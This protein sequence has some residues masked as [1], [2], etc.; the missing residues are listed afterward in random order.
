MYNIY[1]Y[2]IVIYSKVYL[3]PMECVLYSNVYIFVI[4]SWLSCLQMQ[5]NKKKKQ[6]LLQDLELIMA[7][8]HI[9]IDIYTDYDCIFQ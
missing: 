6:R 7:K 8:L 2:I 9:I 5:E 1:I 4:V 3:Q